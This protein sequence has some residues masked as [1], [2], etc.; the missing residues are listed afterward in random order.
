MKVTLKGISEY[1]GTTIFRGPTEITGKLKV[2]GIAAGKA[3]LVGRDGVVYGATPAGEK[4][5][6]GPAGTSGDH[7]ELTHLDYADAAHTGFAA[8]T[9]IPTRASLGLATTNSPQFAGINLG[10]ASDTTLT[11]LAAGRIGVEGKEVAAATPGATG[12]V[13]TVVAGHWASAPETGGGAVGAVVSVGSVDSSDKPTSGDTFTLLASGHDAGFYRMSFTLGTIVAGFAGDK[14]ALDC[15]YHD[16]TAARTFVFGASTSIGSAAILGVMSLE[17]ANTGHYCG[18]R[19]FYSDGSAAILLG[20][21]SATLLGD[22][23]ALQIR[24]RLEYLGA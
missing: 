14:I 15:R 3:L 22:S 2:R 5:D 6:T 4:G 21:N 7:A 24:A 23:L 16:E 13:M 12:E 9:D 1:L 10:H 19:E 20:V 18:R 8:I 17:S 11:R